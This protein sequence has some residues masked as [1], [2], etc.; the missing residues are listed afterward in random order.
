MMASG[1]CVCV[2]ACG[3][4]RGRKHDRKWKR[5]NIDQFMCVQSTH[6]NWSVFIH[7]AGSIGL[8]ITSTSCRF[9]WTCSVSTHWQWGQR[10]ATWPTSSSTGA[11]CSVALAASCATQRTLPCVDRPTDVYTQNTSLH[12]CTHIIRITTTSCHQCM[13]VYKHTQRLHYLRM[14]TR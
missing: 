10:T 11:L 7:P 6:M 9:L 5:K 13:Y 8:W 14:L 12:R 2:C 1:A 3:G 4:Y